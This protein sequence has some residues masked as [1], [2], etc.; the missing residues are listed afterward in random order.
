MSRCKPLVIGHRGYPLRYEE[1]TLE[2]L[3]QA[4]KHGADGIET[5]LQLTLD[6]ELVLMHDSVWHS[7]RD[8]RIADS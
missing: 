2:S 1:N 5:D 8:N 6:K 4:L 3:E 7:H